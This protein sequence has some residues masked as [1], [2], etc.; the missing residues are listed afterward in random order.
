[1]VAVELLIMVLLMLMLLMLMLVMLLRL[2]LVMM[3]V[4]IRKCSIRK[5]QYNLSIIVAFVKCSC[6]LGS[7]ISK[8]TVPSGM[9]VA[10]PDSV[11]YRNSS[12][13]YEIFMII[14]ILQTNIVLLLLFFL[15]FF[16]CCFFAFKIQ[17]LNFTK[18]QPFLLDVKHILLFS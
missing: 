17:S 6:G 11:I 7:T 4:I 3:M 16:C 14:L 10:L 13:V 5:A 2:L 12:R 15:G 8:Q 1:M 18:I 9:A